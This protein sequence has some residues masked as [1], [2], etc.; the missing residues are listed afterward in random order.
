MRTIRRLYFYLLT[1]ISLEVVL[2][3][4]ITLARTVFD[5][6]SLNNIGDQIAGGL[7]FLIVGLPMFLFHWIFVQRD[8][9]RDTEERSSLLREIFLY[10]T[11]LA[12]LIPIAQN[13]IALANRV[14][15]GWMTID[16]N[17]AFLGSEQTTADNLIAI[18]MMG[19]A[20]YYFHSVLKNEWAANIEGNN[21]P[22]TRRLFRYIWMLYS[23]VLLVF[24]MVFILEFIF[25]TPV[26]FGNPSRELLANG[27]SILVV[28]APLWVYN[29]QIIQRSLTDREE[30]VSTFRL[31]VL[32]LLTLGGIIT[33]LFSAGWVLA[34]VLNN[35]LSTSP[36]DFTGLF[37]KLSSTLALAI[38]MGAIWAYFGRAW[39]DT[40]DQ[41]ADPL[42]KAALKRFYFY[43][44]ALLGNIS[45]FF[46]IQ[47]LLGVVIDIT[48]G[49]STGLAS[50]SDSISS[51]LSMLIIGLPV[52]LLNWPIMQSEA[53]SQDE[54]GDH[55][56]R[57]IIRK[58]YLYLV[59]FSLVVGLMASAGMLL[60]NLISTI[61]VENPGNP[62]I[63]FLHDSK[64]LGVIVIWLVY[65]FLA[66]RNDGKAAQAALADQHAAFTVGII[67]SPNLIDVK[68][69]RDNLQRTAP[70]IPLEEIDI[71][72]V[73]KENL[74]RYNALV[75]SSGLLHT[76]PEFFHRVQNDFSGHRLVVTE[77][78]K[79][80]IWQGLIQRNRLD[81]AKETARLLRMMAEKQEI[82]TSRTSGGLTVAAYILAALFG[83]QILFMILSLIISV[84]IK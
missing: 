68:S 71:E 45:V 20:F 79:G 8:S 66:L 64:T 48:T 44:L 26:G 78:V 28:A 77:P 5:A 15:L 84:F 36:M 14:L 40:T 81:S 31:V 67:G 21:L 16:N 62:F 52:W 72:M 70:K 57:S 76:N 69:I 50:F 47:L 46:A 75:F 41:T 49:E 4:V 39:K 61:T 9:A 83:T 22:G 10:G 32:Y 2:W 35:A 73:S 6:A 58:S 30:Y 65:H 17:F 53:A 63:D 1:F 7:A 12:T 24:S 55:A 3:S 27:L 23:L 59:V 11:Y 82:D 42:R 34:T 25:L 33:T 18:I 38:P 56:R 19:V 54:A 80:W 51:S 74:S 29:W 43:V 37:N 60:Y 13:V